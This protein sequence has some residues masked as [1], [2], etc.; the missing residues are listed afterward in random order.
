MLLPTPSLIGVPTHWTFEHIL[1]NSTMALTL[2]AQMDFV[3][4]ILWIL[5]GRFA[6]NRDEGGEATDGSKV[7]TPSASVSRRRVSLPT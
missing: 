7:K 6:I 2:R 3:L 4:H 1:K 5:V